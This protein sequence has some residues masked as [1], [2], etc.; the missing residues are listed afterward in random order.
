LSI[1]PVV[2]DANTGG[3]FNRYAYAGNNPYKHIDP[4]GR[5]FVHAAAFV[6][7]AGIDIYAQA[8]G[9]GGKGF[10]NTNFDFKSAAISGV[11]TMA[12]GGVAGKLAMQAVKGA[13]TATRA[14][15]TTSIVGGVAGGASSAASSAAN[16]ES[17]NLAK[18]AISAA[19][20]FVGAGIGAKLDNAGAAMVNSLSSSRGVLGGVGATTQSA[21]N[22]GG[23]AMMGSSTGQEVGKAAA[24]IGS[25]A[26]TKAAEEKI[27]R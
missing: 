7:G 19:G 22:F 8:W 10:S 25:T 1:D 24:D 18:V 6:I 11:A 21:T 15:A 12:T 9:P 23:S 4:D 3:S 16:G 13:I 26:A 5:S 14:V 17:P 20:G 27:G 2:T